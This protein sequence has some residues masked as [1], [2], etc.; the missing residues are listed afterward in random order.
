MRCTQDTNTYPCNTLKHDNMY[1]I[2]LKSRILIYFKRIFYV[3]LEKHVIIYKY[4]ARQCK[5]VK[6]KGDRI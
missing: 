3:L 6:V 1:N 5:N 4:T 2:K